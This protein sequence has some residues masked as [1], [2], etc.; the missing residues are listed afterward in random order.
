M[1]AQKDDFAIVM[2]TFWPVSPVV[3]EGMM[4]V[5]EN[6]SHDFR[7]RVI[8]QDQQNIKKKLKNVI[9]VGRCF[10]VQSTHSL[11]HRHI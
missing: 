10:L 9:V 11:T 7:C 1:L 3:G 8:T 4:Q 5:S 2:R 6:L